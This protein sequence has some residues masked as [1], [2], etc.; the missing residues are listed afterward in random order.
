MDHYQHV[1]A[2]FDRTA[3]RYR[4][5]PR[6]F[7][8][9]YFG[10]RIE[11]ALER[12][13]ANQRVLDIGCGRGELYDRLYKFT[14]VQANYLGLDISPVML[15]LSKIPAEQQ[16]LVTLEQFTNGT[17]FIPADRVIA[18][19][20]TTYYRAS[21][22]PAFYGAISHSLASE[23]KA[24]IS[25]THSASLDYRIRRLLHRVVGS[26]LPKERSLGRAFD[27]FA[28]T[29]S[30][31][32]TTLPAELKIDSIHWLP[33]AIPLVTHWF[34]NLSVRLA[35][36]L[37]KNCSSSWRGDFVVVISK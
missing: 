23:G 5:R 20:L 3:A 34:P 32:T 19:G 2:F 16:Q 31:L 10:R 11:L 15:E 28:T 36:G 4:E 12:I 33:P 27:I 1:K 9:Y 7:R 37:L 30:A 35:K 14:G 13:T 22:L 18:L 24:V 26:F 6:A 25:Y 17:D 21:D 8:A 29:P